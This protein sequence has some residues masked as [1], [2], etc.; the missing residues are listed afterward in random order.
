MNI[1]GDEAFE[2]CT[3]FTGAI[4][5][6]DGVQTIGIKTFEGCTGFDG[7]IKLSSDLKKIGAEAF[8]NCVNIKGGLTIP[9]TVTGGIGAYAFETLLQQ[10]LTQMQENL[11]LVPAQP[12]REKLLVP[13]FSTVQ[14][15]RT[16][17]SEV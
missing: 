1:I 15:L 10:F 13:L 2:G 9:E 14:S 8:R 4:N 17:Q 3:G 7:S 6:P 12:V 11:L 5:I 16:C